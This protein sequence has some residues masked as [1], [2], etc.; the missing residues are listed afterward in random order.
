MDG[1]VLQWRDK[2]LDCGGGKVSDRVRACARVCLLSVG[3]RGRACW[4]QES[5]GG[6]A[7]R[8]EGS[9]QMERWPEGGWGSA[10]G[11][12]GLLATRSRLWGCRAGA[13]G[14]ELSSGNPQLGRGWG[15]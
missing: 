15:L 1:G 10:M 8:G 7:C 4:G 9:A 6:K 3:R 13:A 14:Q 11:A 5:A 2:E 12:G